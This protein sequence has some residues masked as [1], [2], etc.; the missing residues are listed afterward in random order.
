MSQDVRLLDLTRLCFLNH[1]FEAT[2]SQITFQ[3]QRSIEIELLK[4]LVC[5]RNAFCVREGVILLRSG[6]REDSVL[7]FES[8]RVRK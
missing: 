1:R 3:N 8:K 2:E 7:T 6:D 4:Q 5:R